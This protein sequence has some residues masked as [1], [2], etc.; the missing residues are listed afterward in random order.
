MLSQ[1]VFG[2]TC[3]WFWSTGLVLTQSTSF[4]H[5]A[6]R[7][8]SFFNVEGNYGD[9]SRPYWFIGLSIIMGRNQ[10]NLQW[11]QH[12]DQILMISYDLRYQHI[13]RLWY[14]IRNQQFSFKHIY[15]LSC[16]SLTKCISEKE[17]RLVELR[18]TPSNCWPKP[19]QARIDNCQLVMK[20]A[21]SLFRK[22]SSFFSTE[23][24]GFT[25]V[26]V[27]RNQIHTYCYI[28]YTCMYICV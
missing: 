6:C 23:Q 8:F 26:C 22:L 2:S 12:G 15:V 4:L 13:S 7:L 11:F 18:S 14:L 28:L 27:W 20:A 16:L 19:K 17:L 10:M 9:T 21:S 3:Q 1:R 5:C 24:C 25:Y